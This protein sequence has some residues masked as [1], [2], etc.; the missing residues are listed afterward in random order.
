MVGFTREKDSSRDVGCLGLGC[1]LYVR[2]RFAEWL[3]VSNCTGL[4]PLTLTLH[5]RTLPLL[6]EGTLSSAALVGDRAMGLGGGG[7]TSDA[8]I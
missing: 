7:T 3:P 2:S 5:A 8:T 6:R 4:V 1:V